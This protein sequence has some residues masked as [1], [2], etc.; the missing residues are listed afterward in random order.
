MY[1]VMCYENRVMIFF[2]NYSVYITI[3]IIR[4]TYFLCCSFV[5]VSVILINLITVNKAEMV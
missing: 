2:L 1:G 3:L 4:N 5:F